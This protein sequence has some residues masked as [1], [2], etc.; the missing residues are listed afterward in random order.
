M[1]NTNVICENKDC[2]YLTKAGE[3]GLIAIKVDV[4]GMCQSQDKKPPIFSKAHDDDTL[5]ATG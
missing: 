4:L 5:M 1:S 2:R 3:C